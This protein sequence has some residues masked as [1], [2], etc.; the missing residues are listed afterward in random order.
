MMGLRVGGGFF[1]PWGLIVLD[2]HWSVYKNWQWWPVENKRDNFSFH[3]EIFPF[4]VTLS[5]TRIWF[6][7]QRSVETT[8]HSLC[9]LSWFPRWRLPA[10]KVCTVARVHSSK[11]EVLRS[12][13]WVC[14]TLLNICVTEEHEYV[15]CVVGTVTSFFPY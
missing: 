7:D 5:D 6:M 1:I 4:V 12:S 9:F 3:I 15:P 11:S 13:P 8:F 10:I 14:W 2:P